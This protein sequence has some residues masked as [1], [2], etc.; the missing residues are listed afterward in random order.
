MV[1]VPPPKF[2]YL[3]VRVARTILHYVNKERT[4][5]LPT[6]AY[7]KQFID[8]RL[9]KYMRGQLSKELRALLKNTDQTVAKI[10]YD[11]LSSLMQSRIRD[12][13][14]NYKKETITQ[15]NKANAGDMIDEKAF[16]ASYLNALL[17]DYTSKAMI[18]VRERKA[19]YTKEIIEK[20][21]H[22]VNVEEIERR[23]VAETT[24]KSA[25][26]SPNSGEKEE[27]NRALRLFLIATARAQKPN[28]P[29]SAQEMLLLLK[30]LGDE[31]RNSIE[32][33][34]KGTLRQLLKKAIRS[35]YAPLANAEEKSR[36]LATKCQDSNI[37]K[38][39]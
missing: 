30:D 14:E 33:G 29:P 11:E 4:E 22:E 9:I 36:A 3:N 12:G 15:H 39:V 25:S 18:S 6:N 32:L 8:E 34:K 37:R 27:T 16:T 28:A 19:L 26:L 31:E 35:M 2:T 21:E 38:Q 1:L 5:A 24:G 10:T 7:L 17:S 23:K 20:L 13:W